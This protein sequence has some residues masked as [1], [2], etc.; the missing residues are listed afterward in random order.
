MINL[1]GL[2]KHDKVYHQLSYDILTGVG[3]NFRKAERTVI[4]TMGVF[5]NQVEYDLSD[6]TIPLSN[7]KPIG[8]KSQLI[9]EIVGFLRNE[10]NLKWYLEQGMKIWTANAFDFYRTNLSDKEDKY[11]W[12]NLKKDTPEFRAEL[13][14][15]EELVLSGKDPKAGD[16]GQFYP[17]QWRSFKGT[18]FT[19][20]GLEIVE[21]DQIEN[22]IH[23][24]K[25][26]PT[27]RYAIVTAWNPV[28]IKLKSA[29]LAP[30]HCLFQGY[31]YTDVEGVER[32]DVKLLQRSADHLLGVAFNAPQYALLT[33]YLAAAVGVKPGR[34]IHS[35]GDLHLYIGH[36]G[37]DRA[38]WYRNT[39][40][41]QWLRKQV[42]ENDPK[43][44]LDEL[45][46]RLPSEGANPGYDHVP[47]MLQQLARQSN[48]EPINLSV[49][50]RPL[51]EVEV[52]DFKVDKYKI[53]DRAPKLEISGVTPKMAS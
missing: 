48:S 53:V 31:R 52:N 33:S 4:D 39:D 50:Y 22:M 2:N 28:D 8:Y 46:N 21:V 36:H 37:Q 29:A 9:P 14:N 12:K 26:Q 32:L 30:C 44:V 10:N 5:G 11:G 19:P 40:N 6:E 42:K 18:K 13:G 23:L 41:I 49:N 27:G 43:M 3:L 34:F 38:N 17:A 16:L 7:T 47:Y 1:D 51:D 45:L 24:L 25:T 15:Y 35:F 20:E